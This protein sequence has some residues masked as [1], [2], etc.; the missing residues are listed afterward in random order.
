MATRYGT[1]YF[2]NYSS[3]LRYYGDPETVRTKAAAGEIHTGKRPPLKPGDRL[4][5]DPSE[6][7]Y[8]VEEGAPH[9]I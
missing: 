9:A 1:S 4:L 3:A 5:V 7:R 6:G 2:T 8:I